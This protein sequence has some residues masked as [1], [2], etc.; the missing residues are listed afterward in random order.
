VLTP[1]PIPRASKASRATFAELSAPL[2]AR[3]RVRR[4]APNACALMTAR[5][6]DNGGAPGD[7]DRAELKGWATVGADAGEVFG[8]RGCSG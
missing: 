6:P 5:V 8:S 4:N 2:F 1:I 3:E 7:E